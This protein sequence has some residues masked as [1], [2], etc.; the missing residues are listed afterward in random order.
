MLN[1]WRVLFMLTDLILQGSDC[2]EISC[3]HVTFQ[4]PRASRPEQVIENVGSV[5]WSLDAEDMR[6]LE[7]CAYL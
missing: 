2:R 6:K 3:A 1:L 5:G 7:A 4:I